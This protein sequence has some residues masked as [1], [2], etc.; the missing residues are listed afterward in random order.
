MGFGRLES[1]DAAA[2]SQ[3]VCAP[4]RMERLQKPTIVRS[5]LAFG[6]W[7]WSVMICDRYRSMRSSESE[8]MRLHR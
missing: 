1:P 4:R 7:I 5:K 3:H 6:R 8:Y 2:R